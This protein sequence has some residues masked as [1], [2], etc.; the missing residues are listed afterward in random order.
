MTNKNHIPRRWLTLKQSKPVKRQKAR[1]AEYYDMQKTQDMLYKQSL[2]N[3]NFY[4]LM[5]IV[6]SNENIQLAYRNIKKNAGSNT[7]G[8][9]KKTIK[10]LEKL[11]VEQIVLLVRNKLKWYKPQSVKRVEIPKSNGKL[12]PLGIPTITDRLIQQRFLQVL[13]PIC[14]AKFHERSYGFRPLRS[15]NNAMAA[16]Y[17]LIQQSNLHYVVDVD[18]K[19]FFDNISHGKL[20]RQ[21]WH[22]GIRDKKVISIISAMLKAEVAGIGFPQKGTPQG[23]IISPLLANVVLNELDWWVSNQWQTFQTK[24]QYSTQIQKNGTVQQGYRLVAMRKTNLKEGWIVRYADDFKIVCNNYKSAR[25]WY[26]A[27]KQ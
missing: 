5:K 16:Y 2:N 21:L 27:V 17:K 15:A 3:Q 12:R 11:T 13:E 1:N 25:K 6:E 9:D 18:I 26:F 24:T 7:A 23:G 8:T 10:D 20:L 14:E 19:G 22:I 4:H